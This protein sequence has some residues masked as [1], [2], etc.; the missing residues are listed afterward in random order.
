[1]Y[2]ADTAVEGLVGNIAGSASNALETEYQ[3]LID[4]VCQPLILIVS[5][6]IQKR[7][8]AFRAESTLT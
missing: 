5:S 6:F 7:G 8:F 1:L 3:T 2:F 4:M